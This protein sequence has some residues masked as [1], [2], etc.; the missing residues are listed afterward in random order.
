LKKI[1]LI[2]LVGSLLF[3]A[4][5]PKT[6]S[7]AK[8]MSVRLYSTYHLKT[9]YTDSNMSLAAKIHQKKF[10][11]KSSVDLYL[12]LNSSPYKGTKY[13]SRGQ[14]VEWEHITPASWFI[15]ADQTIREAWENGND[16]CVT[17]SGKSYKGRKCAEKVSTLFNLMEAD[18]YNLVPVI[19][20][21]NALR[22]DKPYGIIDGEKRE[23]GETLDVEINKDKIEVMPSRRGD[24]ARVLLYMNKKYGVK[25]PD[26]NNTINVL[27]K[28][29]NE[30]PIQDDGWE[31]QKI[32]ILNKTYGTEFIYK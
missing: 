30:D 21:L 22:S 24:I 28:W 18:M 9:F 25:F 16:K 8:N 4:T 32:D 15:T 31:K 23:F 19:G 11:Y 6:F 14:K 27:K 1:I 7:N 17:S 12:K 26:H 10:P 29:D 2:I 5:L 3:S 20:A 13:V